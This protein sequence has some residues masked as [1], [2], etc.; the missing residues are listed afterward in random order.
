[1]LEII[2]AKK[3]DCRRCE[4]LCNAPPPAMTRAMPQSATAYKFFAV[5]DVENELASLMGSCEN[6]LA[7]TGAVQ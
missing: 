4:A 3:F 7:D 6:W 1:V 2:S 5:S